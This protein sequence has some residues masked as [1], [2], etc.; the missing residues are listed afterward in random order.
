M[1]ENVATLWDGKTETATSLGTWQ[2]LDRRI[3][4]TDYMRSIEEYDR[5]ARAR[6]RP[7]VS[8]ITSLTR[9]E[10]H[11]TSASELVGKVRAL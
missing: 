11:N 7:F 4:L 8:A 9:T 6:N 2:L 10:P 1:L 3:W 5:E